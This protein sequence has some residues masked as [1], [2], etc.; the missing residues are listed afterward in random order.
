MFNRWLLQWLTKFVSF[1]SQR[2][3]SLYLLSLVCA[4]AVT[5]LQLSA[6]GD[7]R[8]FVGHCVHGDFSGWR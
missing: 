6:H 1:V 8:D 4:A 2:A 5:D 7:S 3:L